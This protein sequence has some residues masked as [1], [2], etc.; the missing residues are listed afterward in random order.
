MVRGL[1]WLGMAAGFG[2]LG[3]QA[4]GPAETEISPLR[5]PIVGGERDTVSHGVVGI[6]TTTSLCSGSLLAPNL[7]LTARHCVADPG[8]E[9]ISCDTSMFGP[10]QD[11]SGFTVTTD[12][13]LTANGVTPTYG[14][15]E[16][17]TPDS[18]RV[19]GN[20]VAVMIL[21]ENIPASDATPLIPRVDDR[22]MEAESFDAVGYGIQNPSDDLGTT[23]GVRMRANDNAIY[24][25]GAS[26][27][28]GTGAT[29]S[30]WVAE[31]PICSGD[32]GG[33]ALDSQ[34]RV[35]GVA[36]RSDIDCVAGLYEAVDSWRDLIVTAAVDAAEDGGYEPPEWAG[37][38]PTAGSGGSGG[39][40]GSAGSSGTG[41]AGTSNGGRSGSGSAG[42]A[43]S[44]TTA[45]SSGTSNEAG[46]NSGGR[47][48]GGAAGTGNGGRSGSAGTATTAGSSGSSNN[49]GRSGSS[50]GDPI[51][52][53]C[54]TSCPSG[55]VCYGSEDPP[56]VC[57][58]TCS[59]GNDDC[60]TGYECNLRVGA[61]EPQEPDEETSS[62]R[63]RGSDEG[64][65]CRTA[66]TGSATDQAWGILAL[67][68]VFAGTQR[69][70][71]RLTR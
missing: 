16:I 48:S 41:T 47:N 43:G 65:G 54:T 1:R 6:L 28:Q 67:A 29:N 42:T 66:P 70:R 32:S 59:M 45:G 12:N 34:G 2:L 39:S 25:V 14:V 69:R 50:N 46:S 13:D 33:P 53:P 64:C 11:P 20:D 36:S 58:P 24:C 17:R 9:Q 63:N 18:A 55:Y 30:E 27:C 71:R 51:G 10:K 56:G 22:P 44:S 35:I 68:G 52:D 38:D 60:P 62:R 31:A 19:C 37:G 5:V 40:A 21:S 26:A 8:G 61:C 4:Q 23:A 57:V 15:L 49:A 3:C 7:V